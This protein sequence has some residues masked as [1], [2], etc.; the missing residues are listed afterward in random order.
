MTRAWERF[1][2]FCKRLPSFTERAWFA[3]VVAFLAFL[4]F[5]IFIVP[6]DPIVVGAFLAAPKKRFRVAWMTALGSTLGAVGF[7]LLIRHQGMDFL[8]AF[9]PGILE[10]NWAQT[11]GAWIR[12]YGFWAL[13]GSAAVPIYQH[14]AVALA[15]LSPLPLIWI[16]WGMMLGRAIKF[17]AYA[18]LTQHARGGMERWFRE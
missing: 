8:N 5:F 9:A 18:L 7:A 11:L 15:A 1:L 3:P 6:L 4:D 12:D 2:G 16:F 13:A 14:P 10:N 17:T